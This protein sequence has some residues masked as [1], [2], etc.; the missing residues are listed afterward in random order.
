MNAFMNQFRSLRVHLTRFLEWLLIA[1]VLVLVLDVLWGV[2]SRY[3]LGDQSGWTEELARMLLIQ[4][5]LLGSAAA[6]GEKAHLGVDFFTGLFDPAARRLTRI[7]AHLIVIFFAGGVLVSGGWKL[8]VRTFELEQQ[9]MALGIAKGW[10]YLC[11]PASGM[12]I[13]L[14]ALEQMLETCLG[15]EETV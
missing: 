2:F 1:A 3:V 15:K 14:V 12:F 4:V 7:L 9:L 13:L 5:G 11:V 10:I 6:F 8:V